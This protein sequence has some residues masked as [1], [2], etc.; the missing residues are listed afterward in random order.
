[1]V[2][3]TEVK[4]SDETHEE[5]DAVMADIAGDAVCNTSENVYEQ[6]G[7]LGDIEKRTVEDG[8]E[9]AVKMDTVLAD[10]AGQAAMEG[11]EELYEPAGEGTCSE[12]NDGIEYICVS[13][14]ND[15]EVVKVKLFSLLIQ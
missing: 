5:S 10:I 3:D 4:E 2:V 12:K 14:D 15:D 13:D 9:T 6:S 11:A 8:N 7:E 1:M